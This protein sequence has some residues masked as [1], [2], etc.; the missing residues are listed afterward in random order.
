[1]IERAGHHKMK[2]LQV[3]KDGEGPEQLNKEN[4]KQISDSIRKEV[5]AEVDEASEDARSAKNE[6]AI[7]DNLENVNKELKK[8]MKDVAQKEEDEA[9]EVPSQEQSAVLK[10]L[11][12]TGLDSSKY[13]KV[14]LYHP[15]N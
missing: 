8:T 10:E 11:K 13:G 3:E 1:M 7:E 14:S 4:P 15:L 5:G 9:R 2:K 6:G 12:S